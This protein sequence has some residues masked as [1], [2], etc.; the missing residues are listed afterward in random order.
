MFN[1]VDGPSGPPTL[2][3]ICLPYEFRAPVQ[4]GG[5]DR[6]FILVSPHVQQTI[7]DG[8][9]GQ[10]ADGSFHIFPEQEMEQ[11]SWA[12]RFTCPSSS[13]TVFRDRTR[14][15]NARDAERRVLVGDGQLAG[16]L[17]ALSNSDF[18]SSPAGKYAMD[19]FIV[20]RTTRR[21]RLRQLNQMGICRVSDKLEFC[22]DYG[23]PGTTRSAF[24]DLLPMFDYDPRLALF[25][26][27]PCSDLAVINVK[28]QLAAMIK[29]GVRKLI[30]L[31][32][33]ADIDHKQFH[34]NLVRR[35]CSGYT[36]R[37]A[38][39]G[40]LWALLAIWKSVAISAR[41][42]PAEQ[43]ALGLRGAVHALDKMAE[44]TVTHSRDA[45]KLMMEVAQVLR[46]RQNVHS[47]PTAFTEERRWDA[48]SALALEGHLLRCF[49]HSAV[50]A[51]PMPQGKHGEGVE[52]RLYDIGSHKPV[53]RSRWLDLVDF[54]SVAAHEQHWHGGERGPMF[55]VSLVTTMIP[56][57]STLSI[58]DWT[59]IHSRIV[60]EWLQEYGN[61]QAL[62]NIL[63]SECQ[64]GENLD[65]LLE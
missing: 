1:A 52:W 17:A 56:G 58:L 43:S 41:S 2:Q 22:S 44:V 62:S 11:A 5:F 29:I 65:Q 35:Y 60:G 36:A 18:R 46:R 19:V 61:G 47:Q 28:I 37:H 23:L 49:V 40:S 7:I 9:T 42:F 33:P 16:F 55:G 25:V 15:W 51:T 53:N 8:R 50:M 34:A 10:L 54:D 30:Q 26:A 45:I 27:L 14:P 63:K 13:V 21:D 48:A 20:D 4:I 57:E 64:F 3:L 59:W 6:A 31:R 12:Y 38:S 24:Y 32:M 39:L